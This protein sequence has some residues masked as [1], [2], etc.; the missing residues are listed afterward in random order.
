[1][2]SEQSVPDVPILLSAQ[3]HSHLQPRGTLLLM[4]F[5]VNKVCKSFP[6]LLLFILTALV[7]PFILPRLSTT[8]W[9]PSKQR[10]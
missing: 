4:I 3:E 9:H 8:N 10:Y 1:M 6:A 5:E 2:A 7:I